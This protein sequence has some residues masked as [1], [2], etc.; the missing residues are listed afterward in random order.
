VSYKAEFTAGALR[1][2][3]KLDRPVAAMLVGW[4]RK[5]LDGCDDPRAH[6]KPLTA[7]LRDQWRYRVGDYRLLAEIHDDRLLILI[8][9]VGHRREIYR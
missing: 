2:L 5:N 9:T 7:N 3:K 4:V 6:G 8:V 1:E